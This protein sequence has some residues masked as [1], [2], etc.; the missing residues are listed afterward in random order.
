MRCYIK[1]SGDC[2]IYF[3]HLREKL[4][5]YTYICI[6]ISRR[7]FNTGKWKIIKY[8]FKIK[9]FNNFILVKFSEKEF[10][11]FISTNDI[12]K[13]HLELQINL[14]LKL[15]LIY[16]SLRAFPNHKFIKR[17]DIISTT[18]FINCLRNQIRG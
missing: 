4:I 7:K 16:I 14:L 2:V 13:F 10:R 18:R 12:D 15:F 17:Y 6:F 3:Y 8:R 1:M 5:I 9:P 11:K